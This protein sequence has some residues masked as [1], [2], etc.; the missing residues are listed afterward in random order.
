MSGAP[1]TARP[2]SSSKRRNAASRT[3]GTPGSAAP[4]SPPRRPHVGLSPPKDRP[5]I[6]TPGLEVSST[7]PLPVYGRQALGVNSL[8]GSGGNRARAR[9]RAR[10]GVGGGGDGLG[11]RSIRLSEEPAEEVRE[12]AEDQ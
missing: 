12:G 11:Q 6:M 2:D 10:G 4:N 3:E 8:G 1:A 9:A 5:S 7:P